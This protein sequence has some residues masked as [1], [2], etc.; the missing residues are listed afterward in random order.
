MS[1]PTDASLRVPTRSDLLICEECDAVHQRAR[2]A[3]RDHARCRRCGATLAR[4]A[5]LTLDGQLAVVVAA[6]VV[7]VIASVSPIVTLELRGAASEASLFQAVRWT[8]EAGE[9]LVAALAMAT[10]FVF[11]M[12]VIALRLWVLVPLVLQRAVPGFA[13]S[14]RALRWVSRWSMVEVF[15]LGILIA[16]VKSAGVTDVVLGAGLFGYAVLT[17]LLTAMQ[18]SSLQ[19]LWQRVPLG[20]ASSA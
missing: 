9:H 6:V 2:L 16:L 14:L 20:S 13:R 5:F 18:A 4:G 17:V 1:L 19:T 7:F 3:R 10:A 15:M 11:P 12:A 8:W